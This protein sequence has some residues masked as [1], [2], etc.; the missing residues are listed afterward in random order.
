MR[1]ANQHGAALAITLVMMVAVVAIGIATSQAALMAERQARSERDRYVALQAAEAALRDAESDIENAGNAAR[2][3]MFAPGSAAGF[4]RGCGRTGAPN[5]GLCLVGG[6]HPAWHTVDLADDSEQA[7]AVRFGTF[8]GDSMPTGE[9][10]MPARLPRYIIEAVPIQRAGD[11][12]SIPVPNV[13]RITAI[14]FGAHDST[15]VVLQS[16]Y[17]KVGP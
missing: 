14:G 4:V 17:R 2:A 13:Y 9:G 8:T 3:S 11:D 16:F 10:P 6:P 7:R 5:A 15:R 12:A 1:I